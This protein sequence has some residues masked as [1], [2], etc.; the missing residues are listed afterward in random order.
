[1]AVEFWTRRQPV[2]SYPSKGK[3]RNNPFSFENFKTFVGG[4]SHTVAFAFGTRGGSRHGKMQCFLQEL[5]PQTTAR[6]L[7]ATLPV[8]PPC[9]DA[10]ATDWPLETHK[11][12][13]E[14]LA[15]WQVIHFLRWNML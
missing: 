11:K 6:F 15:P 9:A 3:G 14:N 4:L 12:Y 1:M 10:S 8:F 5:S 13:G 2:T 7:P